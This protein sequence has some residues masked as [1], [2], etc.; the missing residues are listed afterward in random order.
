MVLSPLLIT[1]FTIIEQ[2][3]TAGRLTEGMAWLTSA[4]AVGTALGSAVAG[5]VI[6]SGG[7]RWGYGLAGLCGAAALVTCV[8]GLT[9]LTVPGPSP[10][11][12]SSPDP[13]PGSGPASGPA[14]SQG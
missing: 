4:I 5:Q 1:G 2:Q 9:Q 7:A 3:A 10:D 11:P 12:G 13:G 8:A 14:S 6:V